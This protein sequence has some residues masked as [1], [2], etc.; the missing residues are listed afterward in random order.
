[1]RQLKILLWLLVLTAAQQAWAAE[2]NVTSGTTT[3]TDATYV[4]N[5]NVT[6]TSRITISGTVTLVLTDGYTLTAE[7]GIE[8]SAGQT[9]TINGG[10]ANSGRLVINGCSVGD[11]GIGAV[12]VGTL[13]INGGNITVTGGLEAAGIGGS[14]NN[15]SGGSITI[16][17]GIVTAQGGKFAA[18]I[19]GGGYDPAQGTHLGLCGTIAINGGKVTALG[20]TWEDDGGKVV[21][22]GIGPG[23][24][25]YGDDAAPT[26]TSGSL[27]IGWN[28]P[29]DFVRISGTVSTLNLSGKTQTYTSRL[30]S[31]AFASDKIFVIDGEQHLA[32]TADIDGKK[33]TP[34][35]ALA[36]NADNSSVLTACNGGTLAVLLKGR[37]IARN[38]MWSPLCLPFALSSL[39]GTPLEGAD[40]RAYVSGTYSGDR[41]TLYFSDTPQTSIAAGVPYIVRWTESGTD[42]T[43]PL[44]TAVTVS[45][46][47]ASKTAGGAIDYQGCFSPVA[48][49]KDNHQQRFL[50]KDNRVYWPSAN[51]T[52]GACRGYFVLNSSQAA[53]LWGGL[54]TTGV[55]LG[56]DNITTAIST[57]HGSPLTDNDS[58]VW[59]TLDG[60]RLQG[61]P[62]SKG[63]YVTQGRKT[64]IK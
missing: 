60:R 10:T 1:M 32:T 55:S 52:I 49:E 38:G 2:V 5:S 28:H 62:A 30:Q 58:A 11:A 39:N 21:T 26:A 20:G 56:S 6:I 37:A 8:L 29:A 53:S 61:M 27:T 57:I 9:L 64:V 59:Y 19:G 34:A 24:T 47:A 14:F 42:L 46:T 41:V 36:N 4:V 15:T 22:A 18:A 17:G 45:Q 25:E 16:N 43:D 63:I 50:G 54:S 7:K 51:V 40:V 12:A 44:F 35:I 33:I 3:M 48:L 23:L 13:V 31:I